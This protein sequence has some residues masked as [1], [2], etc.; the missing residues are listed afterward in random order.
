MNNIYTRSIKYDNKKKIL[1]AL[2]DCLHVKM[3]STNK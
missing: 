2:D 3:E 1:I